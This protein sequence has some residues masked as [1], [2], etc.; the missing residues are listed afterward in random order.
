MKKLI[1]MYNEKYGDTLGVIDDDFNKEQMYRIYY[2]IKNNCDDKDIQDRIKMITLDKPKTL[3]QQL[4]KLESENVAM[5][6]SNRYR[7]K[8]KEVFNLD[9]LDKSC[10][11]NIR[12]NV[13]DYVSMFDLVNVADGKEIV[14]WKFSSDDGQYTMTH[15][16]Y[17]KHDLYQ[18]LTFSKGGL[19]DP[20]YPY[21]GTISFNNVSIMLSL[22]FNSSWYPN[23]K[24]VEGGKEWSI[25]Y[26]NEDTTKSNWMFSATG[27][28]II[29]IGFPTKWTFEIEYYEDNPN[30]VMN[31]FEGNDVL[32]QPLSNFTNGTYK[33]DIENLTFDKVYNLINDVANSPYGGSALQFFYNG[34]KVGAFLLE[35]Y[36]PYLTIGVRSSSNCLWVSSSSDCTKIDIT[37]KTSEDDPTYSKV[38]KREFYDRISFDEN[39]NLVIKINGVT[40]KFKPIDEE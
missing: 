30:F 38:T 22:K 26:N 9:L 5:P 32:I 17:Y 11:K 7:V 13:I 21:T 14:T 12:G 15:Y 18:K 37:N 2:F 10:G 31:L 23:E 20:H 36:D 8:R 1:K 35:S 3:E 6:Q 33:F 28:D 16:D 24:Y 34:E 25:S 29:K 40:K 27:V 19:S 4:T 39:N